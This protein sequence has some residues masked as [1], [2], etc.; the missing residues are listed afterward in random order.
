MA[1]KIDQTKQKQIAKALGAD[2]IV[3][4]PKRKFG[5]PVAWIELVNMFNHRLISRGG[6]PSD[7]SWDTR[8]LV[9]FSRQIWKHLS[10]TAKRMS[11]C[12]LK[13]GPAQL[14]G[15]MIERDFTSSHKVFSETKVKVTLYKS[16]IEIHQYSDNK[17]MG[18]RTSS[19]AY[20]HI[21]IR[22]E[23]TTVSSELQFDN[24]SYL[25]QSDS[26]GVTK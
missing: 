19:V 10:R 23:P 18:L 2:R 7:P 26:I 8:R 16:F 24:P 13:V 12:G 22:Y 4:L 17:G 20:P 11:I 5:G 3:S 21:E 9:P 1:S 14:A 15:M 6:R 25:L